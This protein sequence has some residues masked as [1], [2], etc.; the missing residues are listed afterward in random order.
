MRSPNFREQVFLKVCKDELKVEIVRE[1]KFHPKRQWRF[2]FCIPTHMIAIEV[3]GGA[4]TQG[5]HTRGAG[6]IGDMEKY[7]EAVILGWKI[8]RITPEMMVKTKTFDDL[9]RLIVRTNDIKL[10]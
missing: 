10:P 2:D 8:Y 3:E 1:L 9:K 4:F 5:R 7:N 6:F